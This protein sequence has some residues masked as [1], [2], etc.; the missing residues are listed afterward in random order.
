MGGGTFCPQSLHFTASWS[1]RRAW[2]L[3]CIMLSKMSPPQS[4]PDPK[5]SSLKATNNCGPKSREGGRS[6]PAP[7]AP[8]ALG[9]QS[10]GWRRGC[11]GGGPGRGL[12]GE[13]RLRGG[14]AESGV[15]GSGAAPRRQRPSQARPH[16]AM[17]GRCAAASPRDLCGCAGETLTLR[18]RRAC[19]EPGQAPQGGAL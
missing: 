16:T 18:A 10:R 19:N 9:A 8:P 7:S 15:R 4:S 2:D 12:P 13:S 3:R 1:P 11:P 5:S 14:E 6:C 17:T